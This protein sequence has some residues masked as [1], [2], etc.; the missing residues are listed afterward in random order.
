MGKS[1]RSP[2]RSVLTI[3]DSAVARRGETTF[4]GNVLTTPATIPPPFSDYFVVICGLGLRTEEWGGLPGLVER[5][6]SPAS[7]QEIFPGREEDSVGDEADDND[8]E[9]DGYDLVHGVKFSSVV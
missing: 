1:K 8:D 6:E 3:G 7:A 9:H 4:A 5:P 2:T